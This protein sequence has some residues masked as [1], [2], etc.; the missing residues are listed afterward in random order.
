[1][2]DREVRLAFLIGRLARGGAELQM[3]LLAHG[4]TQRGYRVDFVCRSGPGPLDER[5]R[6]AGATVRTIGELS[7]DE[8]ERRTR[9]SRRATRQLRWITTARRE[10]YDIVDAWL[11]PA[12]IF[13]A[14]T[15]PLT[16]IP[17]V[18]AG[19]RNMRPRP[20]FGPVTRSLYSAVNRLTDVVVA[21]AEITAAQAVRDQ[22]VPPERVRVIRAG[23]EPQ[24]PIGASS[25]R[26]SGQPWV[27]R[28]TTS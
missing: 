25:G 6:L 26:R 24:R 4:L 27:P 13:A 9:Y 20:R 11:Q 28:T 17:V 8:T 2:S 1:M 21:N 5:A 12:D 10:R 23:V 16:R 19:R 3:L 14:L 15:C 7:S 22:G 18:T